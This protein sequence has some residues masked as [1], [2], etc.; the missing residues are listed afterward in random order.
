MSRTIDADALLDDLQELL[1]QE[2]IGSTVS[3]VGNG[4]ALAMQ[5]VMEAQETTLNTLRDEVYQD[6][7]AHGLWDISNRLT[8]KMKHDITPLKC[9]RRIESEINELIMA[10]GN[11]QEARFY[12]KDD[13]EVFAHYVEELS[14]VIIM[15]MS[16]SG[17]LDIDIDE[18]VKRKME[19]NRQRPW[20]HGK[21]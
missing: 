21:E 13:T 20:K 14:D 1:N 16:V 19:I 11:V 10:A 8:V 4:I 6:A 3:D 2:V 17:H 15:C 5:R 7:V 9:A 12:G 18:A